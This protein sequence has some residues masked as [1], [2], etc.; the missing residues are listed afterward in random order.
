MNKQ[1][2]CNYSHDPSTVKIWLPL[3][4][5]TGSSPPSE[6][7]PLPEPVTGSGGV[8]VCMLVAMSALE[9]EYVIQMQK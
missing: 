3:S 9:K 4:G 5:H 6:A 1:A 2:K 7:L 8:V